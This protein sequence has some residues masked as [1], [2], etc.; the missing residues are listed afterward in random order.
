MVDEGREARKDMAI[1]GCRLPDVVTAD[2]DRDPILLE[3][4]GV[5][6]ADREHDELDVTRKIV[7]PELRVSP[8]DGSTG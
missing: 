1:R 4:A 3:T 7:L 2:A 8:A 5:L 6:G